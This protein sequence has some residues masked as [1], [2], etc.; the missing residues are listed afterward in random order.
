MDQYPYL[1]GDP[2]VASL[3]PPV[4]SGTPGTPKTIASIANGN[5]AVAYTV[6][7]SY[8]PQTSLNTNTYRFTFNASIQAVTVAAAGNITCWIYL[9]NDAIPSA[10]YIGG[11]TIYVPAST[12]GFAIPYM[13][14]IT[15]EFVPVAGEYLAV[16]IANNTGGTVTNLTLFPHGRGNAIELVSQNPNKVTTI[17]T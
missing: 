6:A 3:T 17:F 13:F 16:I 10:Q 11:Q 5:S 1:L 7:A 2:T 12:T 8:L 14:S 15:S 4:L 9:N